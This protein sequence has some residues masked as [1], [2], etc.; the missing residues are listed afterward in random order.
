MT[1]QIVYIVGTFRHFSSCFIFFLHNAFWFL[2]DQNNDLVLESS[3]AGRCMSRFLQSGTEV[4]ETSLVTI[5]YATKTRSLKSHFTQLQQIWVGLRRVLLLY[6][7][8]SKF[9]LK[10]QLTLSAATVCYD[11]IVTSDHLPMANA[12]SLYLSSG[13]IL[14]EC[15]L[16]DIEH[17]CQCF[18]ISNTS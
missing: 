12:S 7:L 1:S 3:C 6:N 2:M 14:R 9:P 4:N 17:E 13:D 16:R 8:Y 10:S 18:V 15:H 11:L 5:K